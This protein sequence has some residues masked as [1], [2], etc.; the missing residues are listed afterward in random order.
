MD[1]AAN[2]ALIRFVADRLGVARARVKIT[3]GRTA[4][5]KVVSVSG[6]TATDAADAFG[7]PADG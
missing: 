2:D 3:A 6:V 1:G 4:R 5:S 7:V